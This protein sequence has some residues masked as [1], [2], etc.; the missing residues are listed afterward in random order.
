MKGLKNL[1]QLYLYQTSIDAEG[2]GN[3]K[4]IFPAAVIDTGGYTMQFLPTDT[5]IVKEKSKKS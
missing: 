1:R 5:M 3:L 4:K 2:F